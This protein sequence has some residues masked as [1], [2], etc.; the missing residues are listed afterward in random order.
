VKGSLDSE[1]FAVDSEM[2]VGLS[3]WASCALVLAVMVAATGLLTGTAVAAPPEAPETLAVVSV[4]VSSAVFEGVLSPGASGAVEPVEYEF[5]YRQTA[6]QTGCEGGG[7]VAIEPPGNVS[8]GNGMEMVAVEATGLE[9]GVE[10]AVCLVAQGLSTHEVSVGAPVQFTT[11]IALEVPAGEHASAVSDEG[12]TLEGVLNPHGAGSMGSYQFHYALSASQCEELL[13]PEPAGADEGLAQEGVQATITGLQPGTTYTFCLEAEDAIEKQRGRPVSFTTLPVAATVGEQA[14]IQVT[15]TT[16]TVTAQINPGGAPASYYTQ[17]VTQAQFNTTGWQHASRAPATAVALPASTSTLTA[18]QELTALQPNTTYDFRFITTNTITNEQPGQTTSFTTTTN[19]SEPP[20]PDNRAYELASEDNPAGEVYVP[21]PSF[22]SGEPGV[23]PAGLSAAQ[24]AMRAQAEGNAVAYVAGLANSSGNGLS[25]EAVGNEL[26]A[27]RGAGGWQSSGITPEIAT[28]SEEVGT[29]PT[30]EFFS[31]DLSVGVVATAS[32]PGFA[33]MAD[34]KGPAEGCYVLYSRTESGFHALFSQT[35]TPGDCGTD[36]AV[37]ILREP[38]TLLFAGMSVDGSQLLFETP[39]ALLGETEDSVGGSNLYDSVGGRLSLVNVLPDGQVDTDATFGDTFAFSNVMSAGGS[40]AFWS[41]LASR[42]IYARLNPSAAQSRLANGDEC[43][44]AVGCTVQVSGEGPAQYQTATPDGRYVFYT[45]AGNLYR[46]DTQS[47][48]RKLLTNTPYSATGTG[49]LAAESTEVTAVMATSGQF[50]VGQP[51]YGPGIPEGTRIREVSGSSLILNQAATVTAGGVALSSGGASVQ[52]VV[53]VNETGEDGS[54]VYFVAEGALTANANSQGETPTPRACRR[55]S[56]EHGHLPAGKGCNL[57]LLHDGQTQYI[58]ALSAFDG[59]DWD[60]EMGHRSAQATPDGRHLVFS[61]Q[62]QL[63]GY[64]NESDPEVFLYDAEPAGLSCVSCDPNGIAPLAG[65]AP[66]GLGISRNPTF[67]HRWISED[68][69]RVFFQTSE[70]L[71]AQDTNGVQDVY[72]WERP[73]PGTPDDSCSTASPAFSEA[74]HGCLY[75]LS[76]GTSSTPSYFVDADA[77]GEN[78]FFTHRGQLGP[79]GSAG[80]ANS[81]YDARVNGGFPPPASACS[82]ASCP[83]TPPPPATF[84]PPP[85]ITFSGVG[86]YPPPAPTVGKP[87]PAQ[88]RARELAKA[89]KACRGKRDRRKRVACEATARRR[90]GP[91]R[92]PKKAA[93]KAK[94]GSRLGGGR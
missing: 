38:E 83:G 60:Q 32:N 55:S 62:T 93:R 51:I 31:S 68:G 53:A 23:P 34:P 48:E 1:M 5:R 50:A 18:R 43:L 54:Y 19:T 78:V 74:D 2:F 22:I 16:A 87:S 42:R 94:G 80:G 20:L 76:G 88:V 30:Y 56:E 21:A 12:A 14:T 81:L 46:F 64:H 89:L 77:T 86:N 3:L 45:E 41:D 25:G 9:A 7:H 29:D 67:M 26:L 11:F 85:T 40:V 6:A 24:F 72:E 17:Y 33:E 84:T 13:V 4:G 73:A 92:K 27:R 8:A 71:V 79:N 10:Y 36:I 90:Y 91:A 49:S 57:Y 47:G 37:T 44:E 59:A 82:A 28:G 52:G 63:T 69:D 35:V 65:G 70:S 61:S 58:A 75:L 15:P 39:A 66:F